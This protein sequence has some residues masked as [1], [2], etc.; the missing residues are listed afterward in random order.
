MHIQL[1]ALIE[2]YGYV[3]IFFGSVFDGEAVVLLSG[4]LSHEDFLSFP[5]IIFW[6]F[7]GVMCN[8]AF[9][10]L[11]GRYRGEKILNGSAWFKKYL[12]KPIAIVGKK[13]ALLSFLMRFMYGLR[14]IVPFSIGMSMLRT[15]TFFFWNALGAIVWIGVFGGLGYLLGD[16]LESMLGKLKRYELLLVVIVVLAI[17]VVNMMSRIVRN[18]LK[19]VVN[20]NAE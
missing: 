8:D 11:L 12:G 9:W 5:W 10:F 17:V 7:F 3:A 14:Q 16:V 15:R 4:L 19:G 18:M 20:E 13:P 6:A 2:T 1:Q